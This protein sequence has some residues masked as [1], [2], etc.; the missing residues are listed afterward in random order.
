MA[1]Q[2]DGDGDNRGA[3]FQFHVYICIW[4]DVL[5]FGIIMIHSFH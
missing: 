5:D 1:Q 3:W 4:L 2:R